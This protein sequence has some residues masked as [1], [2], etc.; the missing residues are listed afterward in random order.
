M[1][2]NIFIFSFP[3]SKFFVQIGAGELPDDTTLICSRGSD[4]FAF[5]TYI[6]YLV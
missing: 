6:F 5:L 4:R 2:E 3:K 1:I